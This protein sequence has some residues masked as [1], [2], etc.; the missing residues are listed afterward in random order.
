MSEQS[1]IGTSF[2]VH[3]VPGDPKNKVVLLVNPPVYDTQ[4]WAR[5]SQP[6]GLL[7]ISS[8]LAKHGYKRRELFD[9]M[10]VDGEGRVPRH[11]ISVGESYGEREQP[12]RP[13]MPWHIAKNGQVLSLWKF[14][15]GKTW[16]QFETWLDDHGFTSE[17]PPDEVWISAVMTYWWESVRD[18]ISRLRRRFGKRTTIILGGIYPTLCPEHA[19]QFT[20]ADLVVVGEVQEANNLWPD[21]S[22]YEKPPTYAIVTPSRGCPYNCSYCAQRT[23]N[24]GH[25]SVRYRTAEDIVAEMRHQHETYGICEFAFYADFLLWDVESNFQRVLELLVADKSRHLHLHAPEG[26]DVRCLSKSQRLVDLM[27]AAHFEKVYLPVESI[28]EGY[29]RTM[30]RTHVTVRHF[31]DAVK[32]CEQAGFRL[33]NLDVNTFVLY[34]LPQERIERVVQTVLFVSEVVGSIIPML[35]TPVPTTG[36]YA[37]H[38]PYFHERGW[39]HDLHMLNGK[40]YPFLEMNEGSLEDYIDLQRLMFMLNAQYRDRSFQLFGATEVARAFRH[41]LN[42]GFAESMFDLDEDVSSLANRKS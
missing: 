3:Q 27:K 30:G 16:A 25:R 2:A 40:V 32:R 33:R 14:H 1:R 18:L 21:L 7:R 6:Y 13:A 23:I 19:A 20:D 11:R 31:I 35:F 8:L 41:N 42:N 38:L 34:G 4:Y 39:D 15:F 28:D 36:V 12:T 17:K 37:E 22:L 10:G 24:G 26:L 5:W 9:F 29:L